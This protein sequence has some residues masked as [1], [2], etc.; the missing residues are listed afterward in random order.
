MKQKELDRL[1]GNKLF[2]SSQLAPVE[3]KYLQLFIWLIEFLSDQ[4]QQSVVLPL[5]NYQ[6]GIGKELSVNFIDKKE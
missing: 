4:V 1:T 2:I 3:L 6:T 5:R